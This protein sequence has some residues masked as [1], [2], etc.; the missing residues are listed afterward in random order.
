LDFFSSVFPLSPARS[1]VAVAAIVA[2]VAVVAA[3]AAHRTIRNRQNGNLQFNTFQEKKLFSPNN[4]TACLSQKG[5]LRT[6]P[7]F[8]FSLRG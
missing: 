5:F 6:G 1:H 3:V 2:A 4:F 8:F 7:E